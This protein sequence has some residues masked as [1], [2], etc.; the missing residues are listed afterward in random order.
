M[1]RVRWLRCCV[2]ELQQTRACDG[3]VEAHHAGERGL[4]QKCSDRET[5]PLCAAHHR[6]WHDCAGI[7]SGWSKEHRREFA[8]RAIADTQ[9]K[10]GL[11]AALAADEEVPW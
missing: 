2:E 4:G 7:F 6:Q 3:A 10:V 9:R 5:I 8:A 1:E 11:A